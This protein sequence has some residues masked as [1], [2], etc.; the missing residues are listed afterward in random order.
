MQSFF[1]KPTAEFN[2]YNL[3]DHKTGWLPSFT[4]RPFGKVANSIKKGVSN[5]KNLFITQSAHLH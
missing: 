5:E 4:A 1:C 2:K 3:G